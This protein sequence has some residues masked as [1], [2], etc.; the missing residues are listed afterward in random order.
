MRLTITVDRAPG[1]RGSSMASW[2]LAAAGLGLVLSA[3]DALADPSATPEATPSGVGILHL[4]AEP[5]YDT[6]D[7]LR[8]RYVLADGFF[9]TE[10]DAFPADT[11]IFLDRSLPAGPIRVFANDSACEGTV[12]VEANVEVDVV[13]SAEDDVCT[14]ST[15]GSHAPGAIQHPEPRTAIGVIVPVG[16]EV[17]VRALDPGSA[18]A[19]IRRPANEH[20]KVLGVE[21]PPGR[22]ELSVVIDGEVLNTKD[23]EIARGQDFVWNLKVVAADVPR[24]CG[25]YAAAECEA[26]ITEAYAWGFYIY[27]P[28]QQ[29]VRSVT[30][31]PTRYGSCDGSAAVAKYDVAFDVLNARL[32]EITVAE[33]QGRLHVCTY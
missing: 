21:V 26:I 16:A 27:D 18:T 15:S 8:L 5:G 25:E 7:A 11:A 23:I 33:N 19:E 24:D 9:V 17:V 4:I 30:V 22:Y 6:H 10:V 13:L 32:L 20:G 28:D 29:V 14:V 3:C 2:L 31:R 12:V 1:R